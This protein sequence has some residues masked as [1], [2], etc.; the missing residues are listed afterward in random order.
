[1]DRLVKGKKYKDPLTR[2][3]LALLVLVEGILC[4]TCG[5]TNI[6][7][8]VVRKLDNLDEFLNYPWGRESFLLTVRSTKS[9]RPSHYVL[10]DTMAIQSFSHAMVLVTVAACPS[11]L[12]KPGAVTPLDDESKSSEDIV[13]ELLDRKFSVNVVSAKAVDQK[14][15]VTFSK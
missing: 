4:P 12:L 6:R 3:R 2:L 8:E 15:Q 10:H 13:N 7:P 11:I 14:A 9:R 1:I 5:T